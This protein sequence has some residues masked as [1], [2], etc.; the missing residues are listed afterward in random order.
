MISLAKGDCCGCG[1]CADI[2]PRSAIVMREDDEGF[3]YP[4]IAP[5]KCV[6]CHAC[7]KVC[8]IQNDSSSNTKACGGYIVQHINDEIRKQST[9]GG[10]F[11]AFAKQVLMQDGVVYGAAF[12]QE[13]FY[14]RHRPAHCEEELQFFRNS[15]YVQSDMTK[16]FADISLNLRQ[17][18]T[19]CF[20]GT[21]CQVAAIHKHFPTTENLYLIDVVCREVTS[22]LLLKKYIGYQEARS[23]K[24][25]KSLRFRDK[26]YGYYYSVIDVEFDDSTHYR[27]PLHYDPYLRAFFSNVHSRQCCYTCPFRVGERLSDITIYDAHNIEKCTHLIKDDLGATKVIVNSPKGKALFEACRLDLRVEEV[28]AQLLLDEQVDHLINYS[29]IADERKKFWSDAENMDDLELFR[30]YYPLKLI[31]VRLRF[32]IKVFLYKVGLI[33]Q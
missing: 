22:P 16:I 4:V 27:R 23:G 1:N 5:D 19:V 11:T 20:S 6:N 24:K 17:G 13:K 2:C 8:P 21:P 26:Y 12:D 3:L 29:Q 33:K 10:A 15:K 7:E 30:K 14:V 28:S 32:A 9:S 18:K 25:V 31:S